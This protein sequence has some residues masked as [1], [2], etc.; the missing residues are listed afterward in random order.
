MSRLCTDSEPLRITF[1]VLGDE[2]DV[3]IFKYW[4]MNKHE[5]WARVDVQ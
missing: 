2:Q 5:L 1:Q 4:A 3:K